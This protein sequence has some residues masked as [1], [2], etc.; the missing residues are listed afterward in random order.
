MLAACASADAGVYNFNFNGMNPSAPYTGVEI[1]YAYDATDVSGGNSLGCGIKDGLNWSGTWLNGCAGITP[2]QAGTFSYI[3][4]DPGITDGV[5]SVYL[6]SSGLWTHGTPYAIGLTDGGQTQELA[7]V[8]GYD[9]TQTVPE[10]SSLAL[11]SVAFAALVG[12]R[13]RK[14]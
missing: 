8:A 11:L 1:L 12:L 14:K 4:N 10:P 5:F 13:R 9:S 2:F 7:G 3:Y 6:A